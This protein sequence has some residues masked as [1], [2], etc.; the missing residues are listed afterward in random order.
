MFDPPSP[1]DEQASVLQSFPATNGGHYSLGVIRIW[2]ALIVSRIRA[3]VWHKLKLK[4]KHKVE[5]VGQN[6]DA[7]LRLTPLG[8]RELHIRWNCDVGAARIL[9]GDDFKLMELWI[10]FLGDFVTGDLEYSGIHFHYQGWCQWPCHI[11]IDMTWMLHILAI[12]VPSTP[13]QL[14]IHCKIIKFTSYSQILWEKL[15]LWSFGMYLMGLTFGEPGLHPWTRR[16]QQVST[17]KI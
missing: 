8:G 3:Y 2:L 9:G 14:R 17:D 4:G 13:K 12:S 6:C 15:D 5:Q 10:T 11:T 16:H 7:T 1:T